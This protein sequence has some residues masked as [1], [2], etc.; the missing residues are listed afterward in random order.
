M[1]CVAKAMDHGTRIFVAKQF[2]P[3]FKRLRDFNGYRRKYG[4]HRHDQVN[5]CKMR[6][7]VFKTASKREIFWQN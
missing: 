6:L 3:S 1:G 7:M 5:A 2:S 4:L